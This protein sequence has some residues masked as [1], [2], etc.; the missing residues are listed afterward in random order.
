MVSPGSSEALFAAI[1]WQRPW[2]APFKPVALQVLQ[3]P[4]WRLALNAEAAAIGLRN[5]RELPIRFVPQQYLPS[6]VPYERFI[7]DSGCVPTRENLHDFF[8]ALVWLIYPKIKIRLNAL[9]VAELEKF[10][11]PAIGNSS[12]SGLDRG[13]LRDAATI[14][15]ENAAL[16][17]T[18][19][20]SLI[21]ALRAHDWRDVFIR[22]RS[23]F[24]PRCELRLFGHALIEKLVSPYKAITAHVRPLLVKEMFFE[25]PECDRRAWVNDTIAQQLADGLTMAGF[26]PLPVLGMPGWWPCQDEAFYEDAAVFRP[27]KT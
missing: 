21:D 20:A 24:G 26:T 7:S 6:D 3:A 12:K 10:T 4:D 25:M 27:K 15:D 11:T 23:V 18:S 16:M 19:D 2:L 17:M 13:R 22:R 9:Q 8:N 5:H 14:F 1:D